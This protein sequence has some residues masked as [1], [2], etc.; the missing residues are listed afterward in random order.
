MPTRLKKIAKWLLLVVVVGFGL[1]QFATPAR[2]NP[3]IAPG[4]DAF[5][6]NAP[7]PHIAKMLRAACY[8]CHSNETK[9][10]WYSRVAPV[11]IWVVDHIEDG[12]KKLNFSDWPFDRPRR[13][14]SHWQ[15]IRDEVEGGSMPLKSYIWGHSEAV[16][17][18][19]DRED[20]A[21][22]ADEQAKAIP[23]DEE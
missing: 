9:W 11:S 8:D 5:A 14:R 17:T 18:D 10:P 20:L 23:K 3:P 15:N 12:R 22:W 2:T 7:P 1:L 13:M 6:T 21:A 4:R 16:L 19:K